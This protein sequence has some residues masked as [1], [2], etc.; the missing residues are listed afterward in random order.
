MSLQLLAL[1]K[2]LQMPIWVIQSRSPVVK[3][4]QTEPYAKK[5]PLSK[6]LSLASTNSDTPS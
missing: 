1:S 6:H 2:A 4:G 3:I 5:S